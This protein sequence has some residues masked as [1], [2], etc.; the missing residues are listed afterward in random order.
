MAPRLWAQE[1]LS[2]NWDQSLAYLSFPWLL[3]NSVWPSNAVQKIQFAYRLICL[4]VLSTK[5]SSPNLAEYTLNA[6][7]LQVAQPILP[8]NPSILGG[9]KREV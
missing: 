2:P 7:I 1:T 9:T 5:A 3:P 6:V 8:S 4:K